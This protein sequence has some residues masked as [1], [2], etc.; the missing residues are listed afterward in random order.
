MPEEVPG[1]HH[2]TTEPYCDAHLQSPLRRSSA[3]V[4]VWVPLVHVVKGGWVGCRQRVP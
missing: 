4:A 3:A 2:P 1:F